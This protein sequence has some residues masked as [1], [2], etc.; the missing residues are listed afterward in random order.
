MDR[1]LV[2]LKRRQSFADR[3]LEIWDGMKVKYP[4]GITKKNFEQ[5]KR[6]IQDKEKEDRK[7]VA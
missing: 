3:R 4:E 7:C 6:E 1:D 5:V 2:R